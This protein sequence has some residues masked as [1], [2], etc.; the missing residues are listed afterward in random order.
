MEPTRIR[1]KPVELKARHDGWTPARQFRFIELLAATKSIT[2]AAQAVGMSR[3]SA[4]ALKARPEAA[5]GF[6]LAWRRALTPDFARQAE[7]SRRRIS[8]DITERL[9]ALQ[10][11][12]S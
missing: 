12:R 2:A 10:E 3:E 1:F 8:P 4:Y 11:P 6:A 5:H 9:R 7:R